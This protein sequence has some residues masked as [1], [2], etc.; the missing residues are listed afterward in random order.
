MTKKSYFIRYSVFILTVVVTIIA[1]EAILR[2]NLGLQD[3]DAKIIN[4][5]GRQRMLSQRIVKDVLFLANDGGTPNDRYTK[6]SLSIRLKEFENANQFLIL[7]EDGESSDTKIRSL[8]ESVQPAITKIVD[9]SR[10]IIKSD[11]M[12]PRETIRSIAGVEMTFLNT[13][14]TIVLAYQRRAEE[15]L[16]G[17]KRTALLLSILSVV[18]LLG[19]FIF[20]I[21]PFFNDLIRKNKALERSNRKLSDFAHITSHNL[22]AP[23]SNLNSLLHFYKESDD[24]ADKEDLMDKFE[25]VINNLNG[26]MNVLVEGLRANSEPAEEKESMTF[27]EIMDRTE[28]SIS[29]HITES[30]AKI[31]TDFTE[32]PTITYNRLY[33]ESIFLNMLTN[34]IR[35]KS[36]KRNP[37]ITVKSFRKNNRTV[38]SF[39]DNGL[40]IN[41][42][43]HGDK[44]FGLNKTFHRH[45]D[46]KGIGLFMTRNQ[47][48]GM[49]GEI[50]AV[51]A[52]EK[53]TTFSI[54]F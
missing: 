29:T 42:E 17:T 16:A 47:I 4:I 52:I 18:I 32:V 50:S 45:P 28:Q 54:T 37:S 38:L 7:Q 2:Y 3:S 24:L 31:T 6:D 48:E 27:E 25:T 33:L 43:R 23:L 51:S 19:E 53:G 40:G 1:N 35:Y 8:L 34:A 5:A 15:K 13:M 12:L 36:E 20:I 49:G 11:S 9:H 22:R 10:A 26:T 30:N 14:E 41:M 39:E 46:S 44:L 21:L